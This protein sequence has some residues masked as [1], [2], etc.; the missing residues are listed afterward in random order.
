M[1]DAN[2]QTEDAQT[3]ENPQALPAPDAVDVEAT[4]QRLTEIANQSL[5][6]TKVARQIG[7]ASCRER[8][9]TIV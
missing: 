2:P 5:D 6:S 1:A 3:A 8:V 4:A 9:S 7:R